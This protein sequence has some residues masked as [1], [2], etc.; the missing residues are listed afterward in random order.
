ME[1]QEFIYEKTEHGIRILRC[2][3][4]S[5]SV[6]VPE[7]LDGK[8]VTELSSYAFAQEVD[9]NLEY[10]GSL[11]CVCGMELEALYLPKTIQRLGRYVFYNCLKFRKLSCYG[12]IAYMG[13]G[14]FT[15]CE[16][17]SKLVIRESGGN[18]KQSCMREILSDLKQT[19]QVSV[20]QGDT[21]C[22]ELIYP[23]FH[24]EAV[25]NTPARIINTMTYGMGIQY[26]NTFQNDRVVWRDYDKVFETGKYNMD[27]ISAVRLCICRLMYPV[28]LE[29]KW[30]EEY[31]RFLLEHLKKAA[32]YVLE[33]GEQE[34]LKWMAESFADS[35]EELKLMLAAADE[36]KDGAAISMLMDVSHRRF[37]PGK[38][39]FSL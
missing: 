6:E 24:E 4:T 36:Q 13:A 17:L 19:V 8:P 23:E 11:P 15:G 9:Q 5:S 38:R 30:R 21:C 32:V 10:G 27:L 33:Q 12:S 20:Y 37:P 7:M 34:K 3:G 22:Y 35:K 1:Q 2:F 28:E 26:R 31:R 16:A 39:K 18:Q 14:T 25:E 29:T